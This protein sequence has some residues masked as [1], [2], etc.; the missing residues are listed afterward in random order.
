SRKLV[1]YQQDQLPTTHPIVADIKDLADVEVN[2]DMIT[3]AKGASVLKQLV[4]WVGQD[5]FLKG[6]HQYLVKYAWGNATLHDFLDE[7]GAASGRDLS[8]WSKV[9]L[10]EAGVTLLRPVTVERSEG[11]YEKVSI[12]QEMP[13]V[14]SRFSSIPH[15]DLPAIEVSP[16]L[17]PHHICVAGYDFGDD[18]LTRSWTVETDI[19]A[20]LTEV[21]EL[22]GKV[23]PDLL[24][25]NDGD[26]TYAKLRLDEAGR[27]AVPKLLFHITDPLT[28][29]LV[30]GSLWDSVRD[31]EMPA[32]AY[33]GIVLAAVSRETSSTMV[34]SL[35]ARLRQTV[36]LYVAEPFRAETHEDAAAKLVALA[37]RA[38][39]GSDQQLQFFK[40]FSGLACNPT[41]LDFVAEVL[42]GVSE[43]PG[44]VVDTDVRWALLTDLVAAGKRGAADIDAELARD[45]TMSGAEKAAGARAAIPTPEAKRQAWHAGVHDDS[46]P[47]ATQRNVLAG[48][49]KVSDLTLLRPFAIEYFSQIED[50]WQ[51]RTREMAQNIVQML[52]PTRS[53]NDPDLDVLQ[54]TD[55]WLDRLGARMP[56]L[57]RLILAAREEVVCAQLVQKVDAQ[58]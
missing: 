18:G 48:F 41:Q 28:R 34:Q 7:V 39:P 42:D 6:V 51:T 32:R 56:A 31:G 29:A 37:M 23:I 4:A 13:P 16:S 26:L 46:L 2:F 21:S 5:S 57:R 58:A 50:S 12:A 36:L 55:H 35:L 54:L 3:Y 9:W 15:R 17:K 25:V 24:I 38:D 11:V 45:D 14:Y 20:E 43:V 52:Y 53:V 1:G 27:K 10:E 49:G 47:N 40:A 33:L 44:L 22:A 8:T 30:W 19:D